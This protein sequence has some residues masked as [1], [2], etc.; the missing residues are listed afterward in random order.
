[1]SKLIREAT[2]LASA[3]DG[4]SHPMADEYRKTVL[5]WTGQWELLDRY[6]GDELSFTE[7]EFVG[8][9]VQEGRDLFHERDAAYLRS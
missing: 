9:T 5:V 3:R 7:E 6:Y 8:L 4:E 2:I 1:M